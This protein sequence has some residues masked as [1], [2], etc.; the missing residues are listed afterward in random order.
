MP[1][2]VEELPKATLRG[3]CNKG[4]ELD[5]EFYLSMDEAT[6]D[7][8]YFGVGLSTIR[9]VIRRVICMHHCLVEGLIMQSNFGT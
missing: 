8:V 7:I 4:Q 2:V 9:Y 6:G 3:L 5:R 1:C